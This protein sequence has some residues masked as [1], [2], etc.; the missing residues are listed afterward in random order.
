MQ[1]TN[2]Y[3]IRPRSFASVDSP[4]IFS[5]INPCYNAEIHAPIFQNQG[6]FPH[7]FISETVKVA[8]IFFTF[9]T[10]VTHYPTAVKI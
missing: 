1:H 10:H 7:A 2:F 3:K 9:L 6:S 8:L 4:L 5:T